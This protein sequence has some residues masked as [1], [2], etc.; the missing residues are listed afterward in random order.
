M[1]SHTHRSI[2]RLL[3]LVLVVVGAAACGDDDGGATTAPA[4]GPGDRAAWCSAVIAFD[5][6]LAGLPPADTAAEFYQQVADVLP[7]VRPLAS[8]A[9]SDI[10]AE[11]S[12]LVES[13]ELIA[14]GDQTPMFDPAYEEAFLTFEEYVLDECGYELEG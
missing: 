12:I 6:H 7:M 2:R 11:M 8:G 1:T 10:R 14:T 9:P 4:V 13:F 5:A 3:I